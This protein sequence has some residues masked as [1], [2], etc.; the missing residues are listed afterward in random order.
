MSTASVDR[1]YIIPPASDKVQEMTTSS[2][3]IMSTSLLTD[4]MLLYTEFLNNL[5]RVARPVVWA[6]S[7]ESHSKRIWSTTPAEIEDFPPIRPFKEFPYNILR[8]LNEFTWDRRQS[9][10]SRLSMWR[11]VQSKRSRYYIRVLKFAA[12]GL[13]MMHLET[14]LE[15]C[16]ERLLLGYPRSQAARQRLM[17]SPP[18]VVV[19]TGPFQFEQPA[20]VAHAKNIGIP[21]IALIPSWD[22]IS[23]KNRLV[24]KYDGYL[25]W[26]EQ[27]RRD[28]HTF[29]PYT[30]EK[31]VYVV[32][33]PQF[34]VFFQERF[35]QTREEFCA[36]QGLRAD[37]PIIVYALG[38][39]N[40]LQE[41]HGAVYFAERVSRGDL[42]DVQG[43]IRPHPIHDRRRMEFL[44]S[45]FRPRISLQQ[46]SD[47]SLP[48]AL[49][50]QNE[51]QVREWVNTFR[52]ADV[53]INLSSTVT[54]DAAV[55]D[56][57]IVNLDYDPEPGQPN[58]KLVND[59]NHLWTHFKPI[60]ES[61]GVSLVNNGDEMIA[62][63]RR[64][65]RN[66]EL[67]RAER[68]WIAQ[69][70]CQHLD[71]RC[72]ERLAASVL[73]FVKDHSHGASNGGVR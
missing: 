57:P 25:V 11:H 4:R 49:R 73:D 20:I 40:F 69:H 64:Y 47:P 12:R 41:H 36:S 35:Y 29:Y 67:H 21:I 26:S 53:V 9:P 63:V 45:K 51:R 30:R 28:L 59:V 72:G 48:R 52:H 56:R 34:D 70:V 10:P 55:L 68:R 46:C 19:A 13:S 16:I 5:K 18:V 62:A 2:I 22:N 66:P 43:I 31:P 27:M 17:A 50:T 1:S 37:L 65:L 38:S 15:D 32:G 39:P 60:A 42:G 14:P 71:G 6:A 61:G 8:R 7:N 3:L 23:T 24:F 58:Q 33:A 44:F 54:I